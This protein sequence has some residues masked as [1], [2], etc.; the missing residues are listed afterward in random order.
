MTL[1]IEGV[2]REFFF[3]LP[4]DYDPMQPYPLVFAWHALGTSG[5]LAQAYYQVEQQSAG[6][7]IFVY[8]DGLP[9]PGLGGTGWNLE[10][11][12]YDMVFFDA[13]YEQLTTNLCIDRERVFSTGH[14]FGGFM[15]NALAC[16][17]GEYLRAIAPV[18]GGGP[19]AACDGP[20]AAWIAHGTVDATVPYA[21]GQSS[22]EFWRDAN[23]CDE[24]TV[25]VDPSPCITHEGCN[26]GQPLV[27]CSHDE[28]EP[29]G[30]HHWPTWAGPA[31]WQ[32]FAGF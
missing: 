21:V 30:G 26:E 20:M 31:I 10:A 32:F 8:P 22:Y 15:S 25:A 18:A 5:A 11:D 4:D 3:V 7:A 19:F 2:D 6:Q 24:A 17:R 1:P 28:P 9:Q 29:L 13:L 16:F 27:W 14:S 12:G 23:G